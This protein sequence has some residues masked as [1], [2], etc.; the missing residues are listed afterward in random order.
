[1]AIFTGTQEEFLGFFSGFLRNKVQG[2][3]R[4]YRKSIKKCVACNKKAELQYAHLRGDG[5]VEITRRIL[6]K[7]TKD[8]VV[9]IDMHEF[10]VQFEQQHSPI[11]EHGF[12]LCSQ[13]HSKYDS[14]KLSDKDFRVCGTKKAASPITSQT[15]VCE[16]GEMTETDNIETENMKEDKEPDLSRLLTSV[17]K[18][19]FVKY[20]EV[21]R[22]NMDIH[23]NAEI[24]EAFKEEKW[25][26]NSINS[27]ATAGKKI[28]RLGLDKEA[29]DMVING[30]RVSDEVI[31]QA[32]KIR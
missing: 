29:L 26:K 5:R 10:E 12:L 7:Y 4:K 17:G 11:E 32:K 20:Y 19:T 1:M 21:F 25:N 9:T 14:D 31:E 24:I 30:S 6:D 13:C 28:F 2:M 18:E 27:K 22:A 8:D 3:S 15:V 23:S 16:D